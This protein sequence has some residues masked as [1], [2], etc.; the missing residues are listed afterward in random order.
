M[1]K[2]HETSPAFKN[3]CLRACYKCFVRAHFHYGD[4]IYNHAFNISFHQKI[5]SLQYN[6]A[7]AVASAIRG[8][9]MEKIYQE[10]GL[11]SRQQ[12]HWYRKLCFIFKLYEK[13]C[14]RYV[15][16]IIL[17]YRTRNAHNSLF[18]NVNLILRI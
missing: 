8:T 10:L 17:P 16:D 4:I 3:I 14:P 11:E 15:F 13:Q 5:E 9:S 2:F 18:I 1:P 7:L 12:R 6:A